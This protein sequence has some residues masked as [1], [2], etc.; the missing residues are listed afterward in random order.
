MMSEKEI[1]EEIEKLER[2]LR[3]YNW[4]AFAPILEYEKKGELR[5]YKKVLGRKDEI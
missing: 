3:E 1:E 4:L 2:E 5:A